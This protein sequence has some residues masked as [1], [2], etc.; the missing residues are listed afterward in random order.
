MEIEVQDESVDS[1]GLKNTAGVIAILS[2]EGIN[3]IEILQE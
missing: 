3:S 1:D 2:E